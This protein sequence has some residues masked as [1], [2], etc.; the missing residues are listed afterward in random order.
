MHAYLLLWVRDADRIE[1]TALNCSCN[2]FIP[3][4]AGT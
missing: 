2:T 1:N 4:V 3:V